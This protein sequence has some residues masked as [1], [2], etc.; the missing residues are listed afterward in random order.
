MSV[1][2]GGGLRACVGYVQIGVV[3]SCGGTR[4]D[5]D[6]LA[7]FTRWKIRSRT[8]SSWSDPLI[9]P[10]ASNSSVEVLDV[11]LDHDEVRVLLHG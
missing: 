8:I 5:S 10:S 2:R 7:S 11:G 6:S 3:F 4:E 1:C 9:C